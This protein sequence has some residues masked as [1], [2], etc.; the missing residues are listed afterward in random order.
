M[1]KFTEAE[2]ERIGQSLLSKGKEL[3]T[4]YGLA[5]TSIDDI[6]QACEIGKGTFYTFYSSKEELFYAILRNEAQIRDAF[7]DELLRENLSPKE[8]IRSFFHG[9]FQMVEN[10]AF[11]QLTFEDGAYERLARKLPKE[12]LTESA[13]ADAAK[14]LSMVQKL[15]DSG[16]LRKED[17]KVIVGIM[18]AVMMMRLHKEKLGELFPLVTDKIIDYVAEGLTK[19]S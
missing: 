19:D 9:A 8:L 11:L 3:F 17:P 13:G 5:K 12:L 2:K 7:L 14:G 10:N 18:Q 1:P 16:V 15:M 6:V 4:R